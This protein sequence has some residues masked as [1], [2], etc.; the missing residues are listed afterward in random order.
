VA[1]PSGRF[2]IQ[3]FLV[4]GLIVAVA[5]LILLGFKFLV[6]GTRSAEEILRNLDSTNP[7]LRWR[8]ASDLAQVLK[9]PESLALASNPKFGLDLA[10][11]LQLAIDDIKK[12]EKAASA[13]SGGAT[14]EKNEAIWRTLRPKRNYVLFLCACLG[15]MV[16]PVGAPALCDLAKDGSGPDIEGQVIRRRRVVWSLANLGDN[17]G[18]YEKL[19]EKAKATII[20][21]LEQEAKGKGNRGKW[22][23]TTLAFLKEKVP[24]GVDV[25]LAQAAEPKDGDPFLRE[26]VA[27][28]LKYWDGDMV[29]PTLVQ[30]TR[31]QGLGVAVRV[32]EEE[33]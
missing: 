28:A 7:D 33:E 32:E 20:A 31:D 26:L 5:V 15:N 23:K 10:D 19:S 18:Q 4:P 22:A 24:L 21:T 8:A 27:F 30:L 12:D 2:I 1:P 11:R 3:L 14:K 9:R 17:L 25:A 13:E 16:V 6:G 29:E